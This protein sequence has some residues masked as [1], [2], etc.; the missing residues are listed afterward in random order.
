MTR[1]VS[2]V[3]DIFDAAKIPKNNL[4]YVTNHYVFSG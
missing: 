1:P 3:T 4:S 2:S